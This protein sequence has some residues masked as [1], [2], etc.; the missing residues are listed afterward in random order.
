MWTIS[1]LSD[2]EIQVSVELLD[3][4][5]LSSEVDSDYK[6]NLIYQHLNLLALTK[7]IKYMNAIGM[8]DFV[9][10]FKG[11]RPKMLIND[12]NDK[13]LNYFVEKKWI[14][15]FKED[16]NAPLYYRVIGKNYLAEIEKIE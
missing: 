6:V 4:I 9:E 7:I 13:F 1:I 15:S 11:N 5:I 10:I 2:N 16:R 3:E 12:M 8:N 14:S